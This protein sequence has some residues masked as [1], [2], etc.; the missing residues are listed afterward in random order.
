[1]LTA[2]NGEKFPAKKVFSYSLQFFREHALRELS[3]QS[4]VKIMSDDVKWVIT[5]PAIWKQ[6]AKQ[7]MREAAYE[8]QKPL[9]SLAIHILPYLFCRTQFRKL[10]KAIHLGTERYR[11]DIMIQSFL[12]CGRALLPDVL[13]M[14]CS[15]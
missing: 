9:L 2:A 1:M 15:F 11:F 13:R 12:F 7:F 10:K 3:D 8:V 14:H 6:P 4:G 5:V